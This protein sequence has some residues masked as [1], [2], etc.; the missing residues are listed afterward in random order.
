L[1]Q[2]TRII[3]NEPWLEVLFPC[4]HSVL[5]WALLGGGWRTASKVLWHRATDEDLPI[6]LD[7]LTLFLERIERDGMDKDATG[8]LC[9]APVGSYIDAVEACSGEWVRCLGTVGLSN[10]VRVGDP[11]YLGNPKVGTINIL[12]QS[13]LPLS[14][15]ASIEASSVVTQART[16]AVLEA[17]VQSAEGSG[18]L[19]GTGT[20]CIV[21]A[22]PVAE[23]PAAFSGTHTLIG[24]LIGK[25]V[26]E[27][28]NTGIQRWKARRQAESLSN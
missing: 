1:N 6:G 19:T 9:G 10:G 5:S 20:D 15:A 11:S 12:L 23:N 28:M 22:S 17:Q 8:F 25:A 26:L 24:H 27:V 4:P 16:L 18:F 3:L 7:P 14:L 21:I 13:S 2:K